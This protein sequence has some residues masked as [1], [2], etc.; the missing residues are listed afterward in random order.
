MEWESLQRV[1]SNVDC[2]PR[3]SVW[4]LETLLCAFRKYHR[5]KRY[6]GYYLDRQAVEISKMHDKVYEGVYWDVL[7][8]YR[9]ETYDRIN[10][11]EMHSPGLTTRNSIS[12]SWKRH[13]EHSTAA[14]VTKK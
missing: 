13:R 5:G 12:P 7:W 14:I 6:V 1:Y 10:L 4:Q 9:E 2:T 3:V 11:I 8:Q